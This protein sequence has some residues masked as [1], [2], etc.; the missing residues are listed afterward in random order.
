MGFFFVRA[1]EVMCDILHGNDDG[2][3]DGVLGAVST[4]CRCLMSDPGVGQISTV[5]S[6]ALQLHSDFTEI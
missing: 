6:L 4:V 5:I 2:R 1:H 3:I